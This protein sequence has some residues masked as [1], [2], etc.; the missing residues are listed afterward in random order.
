MAMRRTVAVSVVT[1]SSSVAV[2]MTLL[3][4]D[5]MGDEMEEGIAEETTGGKG[6]CNLQTTRFGLAAWVV[7]LIVKTY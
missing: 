7:T 6:K 3:G 2:A 5:G 4:H 1:S